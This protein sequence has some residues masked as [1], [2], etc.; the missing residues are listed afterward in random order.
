MYR[1][2]NSSSVDR[3]SARDTNILSICRAVRRANAA[4]NIV[5]SWSTLGV[6]Y[7]TVLFTALRIV[8]ATSVFGSLKTETIT[9]M[10]SKTSTSTI[11]RGFSA[12][13]TIISVTFRTLRLTNAT[14]DVEKTIRASRVHDSTILLTGTT[15][16]R[17]TSLLCFSQT[18]W[19]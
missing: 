14:T 10:P 2:T 19:I 15:S 5:V 11:S 17:F 12:E 18:N 1:I 7:Q 4:G 3:L 13:K 8:M 6:N 16:R 9:K